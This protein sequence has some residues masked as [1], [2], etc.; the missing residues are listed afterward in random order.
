MNCIHCGYEF[1]TTVRR[2]AGDGSVQVFRRCD[3]C[4]Q[5]WD[6]KFIS[7]AKVNL[8]SLIWAEPLEPNTCLRCGKPYAQAHHYMPRAIAKKNGL[9]PEEWPIE[10]L[11]DACHRT[12]HN[13]VTPGLVKREW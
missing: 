10:D 12:W 1:F 5:N 9:N 2:K 4:G 3:Q 13:A 8:E 6:G 7:K 11:C